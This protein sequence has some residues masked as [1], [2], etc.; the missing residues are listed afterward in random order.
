MENGPKPG[1]ITCITMYT[2]RIT[3]DMDTGM[4]IPVSWRRSFGRE[5]NAT[6]GISWLF[7]IDFFDLFLYGGFNR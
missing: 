5:D 6:A 4:A 2:I 7:T 3:E 1:F